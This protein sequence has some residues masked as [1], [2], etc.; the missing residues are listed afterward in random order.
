MNG[1]TSRKVCAQA[2]TCK[3]DG[4]PRCREIVAA[5]ARSSGDGFTLV[6]LLVVIAIIAL[7]VSILVP[8]VAMAIEL[9]RRAKCATNLNTISKAMAM[10]NQDQGSYPYVPLNEAGWGVKIGTGRTVD[11]WDGASQSRSATANLYLLVQGYYC[12]V[13]AF[14]CPSGMESPDRTDP[15]EKWDFPDGT[16]VSYSLMNPYGEERYFQD[17]P[18]PVILLADG[19]PYFDD[20]TGLRNNRPVVDLGGDPDEE[21]VRQGNSRNHARNGQNVATTGGS[22]RFEKRADI[23]VSGDNIYTRASAGATDAGGTIPAPGADGS[24]SDQG[25]AGEKDT[26]LIP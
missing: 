21:T 4:G 16:A 25:P 10:Y 8:T 2:A 12:P 17:S 26:Y 3:G 24:A 15:D 14:V 11:P 19:S 1:Q 23:G 5:G 7:L 6:E 18:L 9:A 13:G 20:G 22:T